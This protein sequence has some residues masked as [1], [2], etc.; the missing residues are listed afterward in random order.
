MKKQI[1]NENEEVVCICG[2][3]VSVRSAYFD[4][5]VTS[6]YLTKGSKGAQVHFKCL[7]EKR[8]EEIK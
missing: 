2:E 4:P 5:Y 1:M 6:L 3:K 7:S 8:K